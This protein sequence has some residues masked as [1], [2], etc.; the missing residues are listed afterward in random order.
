MVT[1]LFPTNL[2]E[3]FDRLPSGAP[4]VFRGQRGVKKQ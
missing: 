2:F 1:T 3:E 4:F